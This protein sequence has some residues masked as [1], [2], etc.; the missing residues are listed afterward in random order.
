VLGNL[1]LEYGPWVRI[2]P[3]ELTTTAPEA[4]KEL[5][6]SVP[7]PVKDPKSSTAPPNGVHSLFTAS[8]DTHRRLRGIFVNG[9]SDKAL[10]GQACI[11]EDYAGQ[12]IDRVNREALKSGKLEITKLYGYAAF[13]IITD[14]TYGESIHGLQ[15]ESQ[16]SWIE[17]Y[18]IQAKVATFRN[19]ASHFPP[20]DW[21]FDTVLGRLT[22]DR[23]MQNFKEVSLKID[24]RLQLDEK[25]HRREDLL[26]PV[27]GR[28]NETPAKDQIT[29]AELVVHGFS[30][31]VVNSQA[32]T[33]VLASITYSLLMNARAMVRLNAE[34]D[35]KQFSS[36][37]DITVEMTNKMPYL[38][39]VIN[40][41]LRIH[42]PTPMSLPRVVPAGGKV[43]MGQRIPARVS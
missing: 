41:S 15:G 9:F 7:L 24:R 18:H 39:A 43:V 28:I 35:Q 3:D 6:S 40:E 38:D 25:A 12:F 13:D 16:H 31:V 33:L 20:L 36:T 23:R 32:A 22:A 29:K 19:L 26:S 21:M 42:H 8:G 30:T 27:I 10:R 4:W 14:L 2:A 34:I 11:L 5:Y 1:H 37:K 17:R